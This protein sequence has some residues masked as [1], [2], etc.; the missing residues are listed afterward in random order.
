MSAIEE[1]AAERQHQIEK[2]GWSESH[3]DSHNRGQLARAAAAY[4]YTS[5]INAHTLDQHAQA[6]SGYTPGIRSLVADLWPWDSRWFKPQNRR[7]DLVRAGALIVAEIE[8]LDRS[9]PES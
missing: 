4:A 8:R 1:I 9:T 3:D 2:E 5:T 7:R 6:V